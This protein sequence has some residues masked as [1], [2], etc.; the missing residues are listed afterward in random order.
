MRRFLVLSL[1]KLPKIWYHVGEDQ[2]RER[3]TS[4]ASDGDHAAPR[5]DVAHLPQGTTP[6]TDLVTSSEFE[7][8]SASISSALFGIIVRC[9][10]PQTIRLFPNGQMIE[11]WVEAFAHKANLEK[12]VG[13]R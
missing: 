9:D 10:S 13:G 5:K 3:L 2:R 7:V 8:C 6:T 1:D 11:A 12:V 4:G